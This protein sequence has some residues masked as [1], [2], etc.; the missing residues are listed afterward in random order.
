MAVLSFKFDE[1]YGKRIMCVGGWIST[2]L[3]WEKLERL[4][5]KRVDFEN[6]HSRPDQQISRFHASH[7]NA[8]GHEFKS[9]DKEKSLRFSKKL[10]HLLSQ[11][12][13]G[14]IAVACDM[15]AIREVFPNGDEA[16]LQSR[17]YVLCIEQLMVEIAHTM[18]SYFPGDTLLLVHDQ[19]NWDEQALRGY[20]VMIDDPD[21][22]YRSLFKG[23]LSKTGEQVVGLQAADMIAYWVYR[24]VNDRAMDPAA[25]MRGAI[26][27]MQ[28]KEIPMTA[29]WIS[30]R[31]A[32]ELYRVMKASGKHPEL[33]SGGVT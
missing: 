6:A 24:G 20:N 16:G 5:Q 32:K 11:R 13:M 21:W 1:S 10:I 18:E 31:T 14:A 9:W 29:R 4:W 22:K 30:A 12:K 25:A 23:L 15:E 3:E 27:E 8:F 7:L 2:E 17:T 19:G 26:K 33:D 28:N